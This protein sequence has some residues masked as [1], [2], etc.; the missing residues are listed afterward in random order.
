MA[1]V[2]TGSF[3]VFRRHIPRHHQQIKPF[4]VWHPVKPLPI[5]TAKERGRIRRGALLELGPEPETQREL[6]RVELFHAIAGRTHGLA[7][8]GAWILPAEGGV[9]LRN[10]QARRLI[11]GWD[12]QVV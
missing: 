1:R 5:G 2:V 4:W 8:F 12:T 6:Q 7:G 11:L 3:L 10:P 9:G